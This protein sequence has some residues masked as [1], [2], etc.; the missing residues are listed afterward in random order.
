[1]EKERSGALL[2]R[3]TEEGMELMSFC[4][5]ATRGLRRVGREPDRPPAR[6]TRTRSDLPPIP[7]TPG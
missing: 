7:W 4:A 2:A 5:R 1:M 3:I 6:G